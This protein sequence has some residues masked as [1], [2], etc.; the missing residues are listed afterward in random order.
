MK[1]TQT[2]TK[3]ALTLAL[4]FTGFLM[5]SPASDPHTMA[6]DSA[7]TQTDGTKTI[8]NVTLAKATTCKS[9]EKHA[10]MEEAATFN[11]EVGKVWVYSKFTMDKDVASTIKHVYYYKDKLIS[12]VELSV[13]GPSF[14]TN[15]YKTITKNMVGDWKVEIT[16][17]DGQVYETLNFTITE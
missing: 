7:I 13:K 9:I 4:L 2:I 16:S 1:T 3:I 12:E 11:T 8:K 5:A 10:P 15:S 17:A 6:A 14:R